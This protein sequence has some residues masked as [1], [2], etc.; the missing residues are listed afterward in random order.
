MAYLRSTS[1]ALLLFATLSTACS[2]PPAVVGKWVIDMKRT[3]EKMQ[4][5]LGEMDEETAK[6]NSNFWYI[7]LK[8][9]EKTVYVFYDD[10]SYSQTMDAGPTKQY[11][12]RGT[13]VLEGE[14]LTFNQTHENDAEVSKSSTARID[15]DTMHFEQEGSLPLIFKRDDGVVDEIPLPA[16]EGAP[17]WAMEQLQKKVEESQKSQKGQ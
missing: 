13:W 7:L 1:I 2:D 16:P 12:M 14:Q 17:D 15:G 11:S 10:G 6:A 9:F 5:A 3:G 8:A 4:S